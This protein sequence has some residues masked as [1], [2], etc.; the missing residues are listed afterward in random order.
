VQGKGFVDEQGDN[1]RCRFGT[2]A[3]YAIVDAQ[4][5]SY[6]RLVCRSPANY[7]PSEPGILPEDV[8]LSIALTNDEYDPW[9]ETSHKFRFYD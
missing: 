9:T 7:K 6:E 5:I 2:K 4:I 1:A 3:N 8:P